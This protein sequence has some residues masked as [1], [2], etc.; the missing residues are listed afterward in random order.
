[1]E[2]NIIVTQDSTV[3]FGLAYRG[4]AL[5]ENTMDVRDLAPALIAFGELFTRANTILN[6]E[7]ISVSLKVRA[8]KPGSFELLLVLAQIYHTTTQFLT[9]DLVTSAS[10]LVTLITGVQKG[11]ESLFGVFKK[12]KGQK[13]VVSQQ[14]DGVTL[15]A[16]N[17]ELHISNEVFRL[18]KDSDVK[19]LSQAVVEPLFRDGIDK[20][21]VKDE[22]RELETI[23]KEEASSFLFSDIA[24]SDGTEN[25]IPRVALKLVSPTFDLKKAKWRL[26]DGG[27][28]KWY[29]IEDEKFLLEVR[30]HKRRFG[31]G[32][33]LVCRVK[34]LQRV[35]EKGLDMER[36]ILTVLEHVKAGEQLSL[37]Q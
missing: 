34:I 6:G 2:N 7:D 22:E 23:N 30:E 35:T 28:S 29:S 31:M 19:R 32:D 18:Y 21:I 14:P 27:G 26:D 37:S 11:S 33:Y 17:I 1:M 20:M 12:L 16:S 5:T 4:E 3:N 25:I 8:T 36:A 15:K 9:S 24:T 13:P 10:N